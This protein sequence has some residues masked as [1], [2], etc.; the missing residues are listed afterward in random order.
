MS[1]NDET[2][3]RLLKAILGL[4][5]GTFKGI[6]NE[7]RL[8]NFQRT[9]QKLSDMRRKDDDFLQ[10]KQTFVTD[11]KVGSVHKTFNPKM[12][13]ITIKEMTLGDKYEDKYI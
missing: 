4:M 7:D 13:P 3:Q 8:K 11:S 2:S 6:S 9:F 10:L 5:A 1:Y 12:K